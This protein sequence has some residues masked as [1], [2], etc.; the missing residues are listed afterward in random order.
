MYTVCLQN[1]G[2]DHDY[3]RVVH[4]QIQTTRKLGCEAR[5]NIKEIVRFPTFEVRRDNAVCLCSHT[6]N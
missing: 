1:T 5:V 2:G 6:I 3:E 4:R